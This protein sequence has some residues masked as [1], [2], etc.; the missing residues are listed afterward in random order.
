MSSAVEIEE[1]SDSEDPSPRVDF[2]HSI[3][4][5]ARHQDWCRK[6]KQELFDVCHQQEVSATD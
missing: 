3:L 1:S 6:T 5:K 4:E 2:F